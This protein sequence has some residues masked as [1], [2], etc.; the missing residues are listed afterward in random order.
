MI[1]MHKFIKNEK[2]L[3]L[4]EVTGAL[5]LSIMIIGSLIYLLNY[6]NMSLKQVSER[7]KTLQQSRD[8]MSQVVK[9]VRKGYAPSPLESKSSNLR[10]IST[11]EAVDY[12]Y[13][14]SAHT[15]TV[16]YSAMDGNGNVSATPSSRYTLSDQVESILFDAKD[17]RI[18]VTLEMQLPNNTIKK[19]STVV[20]TTQ[21]IN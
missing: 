17:G 14:S 13:D 2:G 9:T 6:T 4:I 8:I 19:T 10:L 3:T 16:T 15:L 1:E 12:T 18:E 21:R 7:E 20:Y 11:S 5:V